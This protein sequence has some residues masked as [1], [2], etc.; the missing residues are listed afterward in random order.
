MTVRVTLLS[1]GTHLKA[2]ILI[3]ETGCAR[4]ADF[5]LLTIISDPESFLS[6]SSYTQGGT[7]RWISPERIVPQEFEL[8]DGRPTESSDCYSLGMVIYETISGNPPF[9]EHRDITVSVKVLKGEHPPR[10]AG[11]TEGLW[12]ML[13]MCWAFQPNN[14]PSIKDVLQR[15]ELVPIP[16]ETPNSGASEETGKGGG[17]WDDSEQG[18]SGVSNG[19]GDTT[20]TSSD[21]SYATGSPLRTV[22]AV[23]GSWIMEPGNLTLLASFRS[24]ARFPLCF[25]NTDKSMPPQNPPLQTFPPLAADALREQEVCFSLENFTLWLNLSFTGI[26]R[27]ISFLLASPTPRLCLKRPQTLLA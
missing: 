7:V 2:N 13:E 20:A 11:F 16:L 25:L 17:D 3:D 4:L 19:M 1:Y 9:H 6:S 8:K 27:H 22:S 14:R 26:R 12:K 15:L 5:G 21:S 24:S 23:P 18:S 10:G